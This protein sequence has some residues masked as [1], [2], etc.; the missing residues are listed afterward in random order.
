[1]SFF[2]FNSFLRCSV[3]EKIKEVARL[4]CEERCLMI[5]FELCFNC[6][7]PRF[8]ERRLVE[9]LKQQLAWHDIRRRWN[10]CPAIHFLSFSN[11][12]HPIYLSHSNHDDDGSGCC[13]FQWR[14]W[15]EK[16]ELKVDAP[17]SLSPELPGHAEYNLCLEAISSSFFLFPF[18]VPEWCYQRVRASSG[19]LSLSPSL[20]CWLVWNCRTEKGK[21][22]HGFLSVSSSGFKVEERRDVQMEWEVLQS[23]RCERVWGEERR[24]GEASWR[25]CE[26]VDGWIHGLELDLSSNLIRYLSSCNQVE[27]EREK[28]REEKER[29]NPWVT[30]FDTKERGERI[31][32]VG[33]SVC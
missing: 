25:L 33:K 1:M 3:Y 26:I 27:N 15:K 14:E 2:S 20:G 31:G 17:L 24:E 5:T 4:F 6:G 7:C 21:D 32:K 11:L 12:S 30:Q 16:I 22:M 9:G 19:L 13:L 8:W 29:G 18:F 28:N 23:F 10:S